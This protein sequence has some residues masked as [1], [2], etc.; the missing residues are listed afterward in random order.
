MNTELIQIIL[1]SA[2]ALMMIF[3]TLYL[4]YQTATDKT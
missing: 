2:F 3:L 4:T 1:F